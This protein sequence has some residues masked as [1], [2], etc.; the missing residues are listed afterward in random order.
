M[1]VLTEDDTFR[2]LR[3][4]PIAD[5]D[6]EYRWRWSEFYQQKE[7]FSDWLAKHGWTAE[8]FYAAGKQFEHDM[9][10]RARQRN[11]LVFYPRAYDPEN[12]LT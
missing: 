11:Q 5:L 4:T 8:E 10:E 9:E 1:D 12:P 7:I 2:M 6:Q 3:R